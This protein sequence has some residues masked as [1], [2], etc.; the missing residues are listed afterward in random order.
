MILKRFVFQKLGVDNDVT[1][2]VDA[3]ARRPN[4]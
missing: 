1:S 4:H 2:T 3:V